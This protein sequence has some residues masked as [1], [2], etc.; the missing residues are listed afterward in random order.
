VKK[1]GAADKRCTM[2][3]RLTHHQ[4]VAVTHHGS[5]QDEAFRGA[6]GKLRRLLDSTLG[7]LKDHRDHGSIRKD[8]SLEPEPGL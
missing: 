8:G 5:T 7:R 6:N 4:P 3:A 2:E 1:N